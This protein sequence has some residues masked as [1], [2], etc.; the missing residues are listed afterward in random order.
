VPDQPRSRKQLLT[1]QH[2]NTRVYSAELTK[3]NHYDT[4]R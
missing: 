3:N 1:K 4:R 2:Q